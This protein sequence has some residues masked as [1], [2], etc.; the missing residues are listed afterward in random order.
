MASEQGQFAKTMVNHG[1]ILARDARTRAR[2]Q[3]QY[4]DD[5]VLVAPGR[6]NTAFRAWLTLSREHVP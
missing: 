4:S 6:R 3:R 1:E 2:G 5:R